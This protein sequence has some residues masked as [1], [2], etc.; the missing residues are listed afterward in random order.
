MRWLQ[1]QVVSSGV[2]LS[3]KQPAELQPPPPPREKDESVSLR[4]RLRSGF[5]PFCSS[6][7]REK[8]QNAQEATWR[9]WKPGRQVTGKTPTWLDRN[10]A[11]ELG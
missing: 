8:S 4:S 3:R 9:G 11:P 1:L 2:A 10:Y 5:N 7:F 6:P